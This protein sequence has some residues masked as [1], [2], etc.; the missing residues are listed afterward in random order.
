MW[1]LGIE[2]VSLQEQV[3]LS[4]RHLSSLRILNLSFL[5]CVRQ[6][7]SKP[8]S[9]AGASV[10]EDR[11][12]PALRLWSSLFWSSAGFWLNHPVFCFGFDPGSQVCG[13]D[14]SEAHLC[15]QAGLEL[16]SSAS[17]TPVQLWAGAQVPSVWGEH[18]LSVEP[19]GQPFPLFLIFWDRGSAV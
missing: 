10:C 15:S 8:R 11:C 18:L 9:L 1:V 14:W 13:T 2:L 7:L 5:L 4:L 12:R 16:A 17:A 19:S 3:P 6:W